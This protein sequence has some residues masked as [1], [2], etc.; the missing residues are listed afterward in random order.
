ML[1]TSLHCQD[2][3]NLRTSK[4]LPRHLYPEKFLVNMKSAFSISLAIIAAA[5]GVAKGTPAIEMRQIG[6]ICDT[7]Y[8]STTNPAA[9]LSFPPPS[10][11]F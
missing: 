5:I 8:V 9:P 7:P 6:E 3:R 1:M 4:T 10:L 11:P 2:F